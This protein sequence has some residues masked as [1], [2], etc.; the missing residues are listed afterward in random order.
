[1]KIEIYTTPACGFCTQSKTLV[2]SLGLEYT[3][4]TI[5]AETRDAL[6][7]ELSVRMGS[8]PT[9]VPQIFIND[10]YIGGYK[11]LVEWTKQAA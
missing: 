11:N 2:T 10:S 3:E 8:K 1:M 6:I 9:S 4:H 7:S 5:T